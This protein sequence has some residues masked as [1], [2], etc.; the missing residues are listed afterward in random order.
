[1]I[2]A[3]ATQN[4]VGG[5]ATSFHLDDKTGIEDQ[6]QQINPTPI[7]LQAYGCG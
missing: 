3:D 6:P 2:C 4:V 5:L 7:D 1:V